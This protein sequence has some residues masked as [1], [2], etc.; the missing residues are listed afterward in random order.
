MGTIT[1]IAPWFGSKRNLATEIIR[2]IGPHRVYWEPV[3]GSLAVLLAKPPVVM[4]TANDLHGDL[5]NLARVLRDEEK[6]FVLY[7]RTARLIYH[8]DIFEECAARVRSRGDQSA[9]DLPDVNRAEDYLI[10]SWFGRN[11]V[12]GTS[13]NNMN[14]C[15]RY[16]ANGGHAATRWK[17]VVDSIPSWHQRL[18]NVTILNRDVFDIL[19][20]I[21]DEPGTAI[22][23]DPPYLT[24]GAK[25]LHD[26]AVSDH[27][28]LAEALGRFRKTRVVVSY[29]DDARLSD[30]YP[31]WR[32]DMHEVTKALV[33]QGARDSSGATKA[34]EVLLVNDFSGQNTLF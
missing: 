22:Y 14:F 7:G 27:A 20:R 11:G 5:I 21:A 4:E 34:T 12:A 29:Y 19:P 30:L 23:V 24:K 1:A 2:A 31:G 18:R 10:C 6:A 25:Y 26:F 3:C 32:V 13:S 15:A 28:R 16:T 33:N 17:S 9:S 8:E